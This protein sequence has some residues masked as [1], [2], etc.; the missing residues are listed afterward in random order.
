M[1][2]ADAKVFV[3]A[4]SNHHSQ[5]PIKRNSNNMTS[6]TPL[7]RVVS[8]LPSATELLCLIPGG[9]RLLVGRN[10]EDDFPSSI[11]HLPILTRQKTV[12]TTPEDVD[13]QVTR[14]LASGSSLYTLDVPLLKQLQPDVIL[15]QSLCDVCA[16]EV[17]AVYRAAKQMDPE[18]EVVTLNPQS[19]QD[20]LNDLLTVGRA[21]GLESE[22]VLAQSKL[23]ERVKK[24]TEFAASQLAL[25][26]N[27]RKNILFAE[28]P[29]PL[30]PGG[31]WTSQMIQ[32]AGAH[33]PLHPPST[34]D[35]PA[36]PSR[37]ISP[38]IALEAP[39][40]Y[41]IICPCGINLPTTISELDKI[42]SN[43]TYSW[44]TRL[45]QKASRIVYVD[46]NAMFNRSGPRLVDALEWLVG[47]VWKKEEWIPR[48]FPYEEFK[49]GAKR[50][51]GGREVR[52]WMGRDGIESCRK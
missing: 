25:A 20:V 6:I 16:I 21:V 29:T 22:A 33:Q 2:G 44:W 49:L 26:N 43:P 39:L 24:A 35:G 47:W 8:L 18:P 27:I 13:T 45:E 41:L 32:L 11:T 23:S 52:D 38:E 12:F 10:H 28:W 9:E 14:A 40:D 7:K 5:Q 17:G 15:T 51:D 4:F 34:P 46:G 3:Y 30:Y 19:L 50:V 37:R 36:A 31:H 42:R 48:G 1:V